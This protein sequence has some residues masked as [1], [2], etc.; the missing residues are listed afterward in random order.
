MKYVREFIWLQILNQ[1][2]KV[3]GIAVS[4]AH[5]V[6]GN[7]AGGWRTYVKSSTDEP[8]KIDWREL[9]RN[10]K[11]GQMILTNGPYLEVSTDQDNLAGADIRLRVE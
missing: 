11:A 8:D 6:H 9:V 4:D 10:S 2:H 7:G 1:G 3:W 5:T